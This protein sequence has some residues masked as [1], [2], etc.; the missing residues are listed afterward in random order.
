[1][2]IYSDKLQAFNDDDYDVIETIV[3]PSQM[4]DDMS[5]DSEA[6][7]SLSLEQYD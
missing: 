5:I 3:L 4:N 2:T 7:Y 1:M 6:F